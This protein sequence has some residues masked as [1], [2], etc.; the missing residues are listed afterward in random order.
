MSRTIRS[1]YLPMRVSHSFCS[2]YSR[3]RYCEWQWGRDKLMK[4]PRIYDWKLMFHSG[5]GAQWRAFVG[6][7][8]WYI[9]P[10]AVSCAPW[11]IRSRQF[12]SLYLLHVSYEDKLSHPPDIFT[13]SLS[14]ENSCFSSPEGNSKISHNSFR[15]TVGKTLWKILKIFGQLWSVVIRRV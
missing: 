5:D 10:T 7:W 13:Y 2:S 8:H 6:G 14:M 1:Y 3:V 9:S 11:K 12:S 15:V 4:L